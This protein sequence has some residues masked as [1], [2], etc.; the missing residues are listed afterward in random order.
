MLVSGEVQENEAAGVVPVGFL[1]NLKEKDAKGITP[2]AG[3]LVGR[4]IWL[5]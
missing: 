3:G 1:E 2:A 4:E 5:G